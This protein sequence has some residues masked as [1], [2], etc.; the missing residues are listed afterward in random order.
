MREFEDIFVKL[1]ILREVFD[2]ICLVDAA[3]EKRGVTTDDLVRMSDRAHL[4]RV[5]RVKLMR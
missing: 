4:A 3:D 2:V 5:C 1:S